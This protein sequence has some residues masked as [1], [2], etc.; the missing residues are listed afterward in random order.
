MN[1]VFEGMVYDSEIVAKAE[2]KAREDLDAV[3][4]QLTAD[5]SRPNR[6]SLP[7]QPYNIQIVRQA[8]EL[9]ADCVGHAR[10][11]GGAAICFLA[12]TRRRS[13]GCHL[14]LC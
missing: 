8:E 9:K 3:V 11:P 2:A 1:R 7:G 13:C 6:C 12:P 4:A 14:A 5:R 10:P